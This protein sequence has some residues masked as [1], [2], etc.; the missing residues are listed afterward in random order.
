MKDYSDQKIYDKLNNFIKKYYLNNLIKGIIYCFSVLIFFFILF[1]TLEYYAQ[2]NVQSRTF[3][4]WTYIAITLY[5]LLS[6][7]ITPVLQLF[8]LKRNISHKEAAKIIGVYFPEID[9][10]LTNILELQEMSEKENQLILA[11]IDQ[12]IS[13]I[14][15]VKFNNAIDISKNKKH[16]KWVI[17]FVLIILL[18]FIS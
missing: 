4:F 9:D 17:F 15:P 3:L 1:A 5:I 13:L 11:S 7:I 16:V 12:K 10:K 6:L 18:F 8:N 2:L 14:K